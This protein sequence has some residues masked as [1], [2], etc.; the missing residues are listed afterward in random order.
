MNWIHSNK[1]PDS[2]CKQETGIV[3]TS[4]LGTSNRADRGMGLRH[5]NL[6]KT[7]MTARTLTAIMSK[8]GRRSELGHKRKRK[9]KKW[10][11][12]ETLP[13]KHTNSEKELQ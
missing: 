7:G 12:S 1:K 5:S 10:T 2:S 4:L 9:W 6:I 3:K 11:N 13:K 8:G